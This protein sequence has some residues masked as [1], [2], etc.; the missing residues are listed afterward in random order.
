VLILIL[1]CCACALIVMAVFGAMI[2][3]F[4]AKMAGSGVTP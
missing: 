2:A 4:I 1:F 3:A